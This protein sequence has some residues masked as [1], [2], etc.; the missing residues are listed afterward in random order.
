MIRKIT[1]ILLIFVYI[2]P[3]FSTK[4]IASIDDKV[5]TD[6]DI[7]N[8]V[9]L[10]NK[11]GIVSTSNRL[12]A[13]ENILNDYIKLNYANSLKIKVDDKEI[14]KEL[15]KL[16]LGILNKSEKQM[17]FFAIGANIAW[18]QIIFRTIL[19]TISISDEEIKQEQL[20]LESRHGL[21]IN[22]SFLIINNIDEKSYKLLNVP[23]N[24]NDAVSKLEKLNLDFQKINVKQYELSSDIR[25]I[26][27]DISLFNWSKII[28]GKVYLVC[29]KKKLKEF[30]KLENVIR[31]NAMYKK[32]I[33]MSEN[34]LKQLKR[35]SVIVIND[36][37]YKI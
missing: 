24:C 11:Q 23:K 16:N 15:N 33:L 18:Q 25:S 29:D 4:I 27:S 22:I 6:L 5:I 3:G 12:K 26:L 8:R 20:E 30:S 35:K 13:F 36:D 14:N 21:P 19:P 32:A 9:K 17:A 2:T 10:M 37:R 28:D 7:T 31:Q 34:Q 1:I